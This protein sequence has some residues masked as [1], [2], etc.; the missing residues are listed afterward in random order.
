[1]IRLPQS[2]IPKKSCYPLA[3]ILRAPI[4]A[5]NKYLVCNQ[6]GKQWVYYAYFW[7][8]HFLCWPVE[9]LS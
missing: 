8:F 3:E 5:L 9:S 2:I 7:Y 6:S 4:H 1:M